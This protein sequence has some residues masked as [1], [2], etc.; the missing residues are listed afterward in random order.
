MMMVRKS[1]GIGERHQKIL[2]FIASYQREH[3]HPP[4]IREIGEYCDISSTSVVNYYLDQ[5]EKAGQ[6][7]R[8]RKIS[9]GMRLIGNANPIGDMLRVPVLGVIQAGEPILVPSESPFT[10]EDSVEIAASMMSTKEKGRELFA[11]QVQGDSM[12][13]A[14]VNDGDIVILRPAQ[15]A[16][17]GEMVAVWLNDRNETTLKYFYKEKEGYRL[18]PANPSFKPIMIKKSEA[19][20][21]KGKVVMVI[22]KVDRLVA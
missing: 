1:K 8:D 12:I 4:S 5:L 17:N 11:L 7:E 13:D 6:L 14:M 3:K 19:L 21:I 20:D 9:R 15:E 10:P 2:D 22:R 16:R 18:Q